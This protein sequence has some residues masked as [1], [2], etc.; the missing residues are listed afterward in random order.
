M[1]LRYLL[2]KPFSL[3]T[4]N[5]SLLWLQ[6]QLQ[7]SHDQEHW[8]NL[9]VKYQYTVVHIPG[10]TNPADVLTCKQFRDCQ[11]PAPP[12]ATIIPALHS[13][14]MPLQRPSPMLAQAQTAPTSCTWSSLQPSMQ[15]CLLIPSWAPSLRQQHRPFPDL[16]SAT[17]LASQAAFTS[18][19]D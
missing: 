6:E 14:S 1:L 9:H 11:G 3:H 8:L 18:M 13:S 2:D 15:P 16:V 4:D 17:S 5:T 19:A 10:V 7:L 12:Q